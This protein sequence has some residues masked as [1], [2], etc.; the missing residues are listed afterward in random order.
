LKVRFQATKATCFCAK[1]AS[2]S[3]AGHF[4]CA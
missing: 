4:F 3:A 2:A 1:M